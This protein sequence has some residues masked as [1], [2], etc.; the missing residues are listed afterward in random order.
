MV[1]FRKRLGKGIINEVNELIAKPVSTTK[2]SD[3]DDNPGNNA[4]SKTERESPKQ[5]KEN[6][7]KLILDATCTPADIQYPTD[8]WLLNKTREAL[9]EIIDR[10]DPL[11]MNIIR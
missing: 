1:H 4:T 2:D 10:V 5:E 3:D 7:G 11:I 6:I 9:E 8:L